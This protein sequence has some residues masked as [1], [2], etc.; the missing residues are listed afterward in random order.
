MALAGIRRWRT[1]PR[2]PA[3][4]ARMAKKRGTRGGK[5][6]GR[7]THANRGGLGRLRRANAKGRQRVG[8]WQRHVDDDAFL[9]RLGSD[10]RIG[11]SGESLLLKFNRQA[12]DLATTDGQP[13]EIC[14]FD[15]IHVR[16]RL[17]D[18]IVVPCQVRRVIKKMLSGVTNPL[19]VGDRVR[20]GL[21]DEG[22]HVIDGVDPRHNQLA[23]AGSHN[24]A[25]D[26]VF[27]ANIDHLV[28]VAA[29]A[30]PELKPGLIDRYLVIA[31]HNDIEP[32]LVLNKADLGPA[33]GAAAL[34][35]DLGY[36]VFVTVGTDTDDPAVADL[37][38]AIQG[39]ACVF[40]GQ[41]GVGK[42]SLVNAL[43]PDIDA[44]T[45]GVSDALS[46]GRH[47]TT[48]SSS[49][50]LTDGSR[51]IDTPGIRECGVSGMTALDVALLYRDIA[52]WHH[53]CH[54]ND[55]SHRH[56]PDCAVVAA[57]ERG[58]LAPTRYLSYCSIIEEDLAS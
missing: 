40:A 32:L 26:H 57:L 5:D 53:D 25:L 54:F 11:H 36:D 29:V 46:K 37:R 39:K 55:C 3:N 35:R 10:E 38:Q 52:R 50:A 27:A 30:M 7:N 41:S 13:G 16:V 51:L 58:D 20:V 23:R 49:Y 21:T 12:R 1:S 15:G 28:I 48:A 17:N 24:K 56:E 2:R 18:G 22:D 43:Y 33:E 6:K 45:G 42:S 8:D 9:E 19:V 47:T 44:R 4:S 14:G 31:H 34:Y